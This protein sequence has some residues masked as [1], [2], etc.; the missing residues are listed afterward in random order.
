[1]GGLVTILA[2]RNLERQTGCR[3]DPPVNGG[4]PLETVIG[5]SVGP[6]PEVPSV[7]RI[8]HR[9]GWLGDDRPVPVV[10]SGPVDRPIVWL[11]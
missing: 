6:H 1:M 8:L 11:L 5:S 3:L 7:G 2:S 4:L 10:A 9:T